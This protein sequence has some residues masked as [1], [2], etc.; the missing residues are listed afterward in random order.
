MTELPEI[1]LS[2]C[3]SFP[4]FYA[5]YRFHCKEE[6]AVFC[7]QF[8]SCPQKNLLS[9]IW[10]FPRCFEDMG[11]LQMSGYVSSTRTHASM[12][13]DTVLKAEDAGGLQI[14]L[15]C[16]PINMNF[17]PLKIRQTCINIRGQPGL[18]IVEV[19]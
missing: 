16:L 12:V 7:M 9:S 6:I 18:P 19:F 1:V 3:I 17:C 2:K 11:P 10:S 4:D 14:L 15:D 13:D 8:K 5:S